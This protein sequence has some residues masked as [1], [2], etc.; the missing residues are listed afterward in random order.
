MHT[1]FWTAIIIGIG[2]GALAGLLVGFV[3]STGLWAILLW[4]AWH[5]VSMG[6]GA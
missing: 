1:I 3:V 2:V 5:G 6:G 4:L